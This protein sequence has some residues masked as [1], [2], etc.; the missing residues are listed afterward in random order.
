MEYKQKYCEVTTFYVVF[1][2]TSE[3]QGVL[4]K[5]TVIQLIR[6]FHAFNETLRIISM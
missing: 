5:L 4:E 6:K 2:S 1:G 3:L